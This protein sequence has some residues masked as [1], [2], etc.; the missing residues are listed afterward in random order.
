M[1]AAA[2]AELAAAGPSS[3]DIEAV[4]QRKEMAE[5]AGQVQLSPSER[6]FDCCWRGDVN[7]CKQL[8][9]Q[10]ADIDW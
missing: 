1:G 6:L 7:G 5:M 2:S 10:G 8:I 9:Q 4:L 3:D